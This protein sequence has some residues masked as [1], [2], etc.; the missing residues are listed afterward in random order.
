M[1]KKQKMRR[2]LEMLK[3]KQDKKE[4]NQERMIVKMH[5]NQ[6]KAAKQEEMLAEI[7]ARMDENNK[8]MNAT[9]EWMNASLKDLN[10]RH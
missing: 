5:A 7:E 2:I 10:R 6:A 3:A 4:E 8:E 1:E 9:Q